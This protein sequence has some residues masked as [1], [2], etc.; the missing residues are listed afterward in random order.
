MF[1]KIL[2]S[3]FALAIAAV[4]ILLLLRTRQI[5]DSDSEPKKNPVEENTSKTKSANNILEDGETAD[6]P[7]SPV[8]DTNKAPEEPVSQS[9]CETECSGYDTEKYKIACLEECALSGTSQKESDC[10]SLSGSA[11]DSCWKEKALTEKNFSACDN[12]ASANLRKSCQDRLTEEL[13]DSGPSL[14]ST[15][16]K[17][18]P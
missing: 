1:K 10:A 15:L 11:K 12:I 9:D 14:Q 3:L 2:F 17:N 6:S 16:K 8:A 18:R 4:V 7:E 13:L 5:S